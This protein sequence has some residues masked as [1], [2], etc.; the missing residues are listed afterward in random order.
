MFPNQNLHIGV[1][2]EF[3]QFLECLG[4]VEIVFGGGNDPVT[5]PAFLRMINECL[6]H[7]FQCVFT[8]EC[9]RNV[10]RFAALQFLTDGIPHRASGLIGNQLGHKPFLSSVVLPYQPAHHTVDDALIDGL[11]H[12]ARFGNHLRHPTI[13]NPL[14][15]RTLIVWFVDR[16]DRHF[17]N[18]F[19]SIVI[20]WRPVQLRHIRRLYPNHACMFRQL[21]R[22]LNEMA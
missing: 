4:T 17:R 22:A 20:H 15:I 14:R 12:V 3:H 10:K 7:R 6:I 2:L 13:H 16:S 9:H 8:D 19:D 18:V 11:L 5:F 1:A 21:G